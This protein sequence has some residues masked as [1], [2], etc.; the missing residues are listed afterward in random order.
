MEPNVDVRPATVEDMSA[1]ER[2]LGVEDVRFYRRQL[3]Q[4]GVVL[5]AWLGGDLVGALHV[6][7]AGADEPEVRAHLPGVPILHRLRVRADLRRRGYGGQ[8]LEDAERRLR[9]DGHARVIA[10]ITTG[11]NIDRKAEEL[12][13]RFYGRHGYREWPH[14]VIDTVDERHPSDDG[15]VTTPDQCRIFVKTLSPED[16]QFW[17]GADQ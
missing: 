4:P 14:G 2:V 5:V 8:L 10:G 9:K 16:A 17:S 7:W 15:I 1:L 13:V 12:V 3:H 11:V 6:S